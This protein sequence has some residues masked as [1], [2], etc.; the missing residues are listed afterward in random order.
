MKCVEL[1]TYTNYNRAIKKGNQEGKLEVDRA[2][3]AGQ[4]ETGRNN[5]MRRKRRKKGLGKE[6]E[7]GES[8]PSPESISG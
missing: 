8:F 4:G 2:A 7:R 3:K 6:R 1:V 5:S